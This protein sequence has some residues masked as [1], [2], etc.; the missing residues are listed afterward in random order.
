MNETRG[1]CERYEK[2]LKGNYAIIGTVIG[3]VFFPD[4]PVSSPDLKVREFLISV[5]LTYSLRA[6]L[7]VV[8]LNFRSDLRSNSRSDFSSDLR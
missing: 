2:I 3:N 1:D 8:G 7:I 4:D 5:V 6:K